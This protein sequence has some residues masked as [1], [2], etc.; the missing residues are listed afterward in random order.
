MPFILNDDKFG[1]FYK[2]GYYVNGVRGGNIILT[3]AF[4]Q[5]RKILWTG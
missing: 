5:I 1:T 4:Q 3:D 2:Y